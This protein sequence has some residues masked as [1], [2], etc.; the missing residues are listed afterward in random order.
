MYSESR[1]RANAWIAGTLWALVLCIV[2]V[3]GLWP[4]YP[5]KNQVEWVENQSALEFG[6]YGSILTAGAFHASMTNDNTSGSI[7]VWL[8]PRLL[9]GTKTI[10]AFD[11]SEHPG[12]PF[13]LLQSENAL[14]VQRHNVDDHGI[15][16]TAQFAVRGVFLPKRPVF[17]TITLGTRVTSV[18]IDGVLAMV[19][20]ILGA[21]TNNLTGRFVVANSPAFNN[22]WSG[23]I[24]GLAVYHSQLTVAQVARHY[25]SWMTTQKPEITHGEDPVALYLF[26]ERAG[27]IIH[28]QLDVA[29][30]LLVP[31]HYFVLH[32]PF[33]APLWRRYRYG[34]PGW[35]YWKDLLVNIVGFVPVGFF[36]LSYLSLIRPNK[37]L[38][39]TV[40]LLGFFLS[41]TIE[42]LQRFLPTRYSDMTDLISNTLGT[43][44]G[45]NLYRWFRVQGA[46]ARLV[47]YSLGVLVNR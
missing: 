40:I 45:A 10:L 43:A 35:S 38:A 26:N 44:V 19:F 16:R 8:E 36:L 6:H 1:D 2:L 27:N 33:L 9:H 18:Y 41:L 28:N 37:R 12:D 5:P 14:L 23:E 22:S 30:D 20:P 47:G 24:L 31:A 21:S 17:A 29:T 13:A 7:E 25:E 39:A 15:C 32:P 46:W 34:W 11:S 42:S 3:A 4:F